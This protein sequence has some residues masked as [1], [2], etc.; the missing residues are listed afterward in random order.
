MSKVIFF[1]LPG[2]SGHI[3]PTV[4]LVKELI[5]RGEHVI[6]Y[7]G[8]DSRLKFTG[9]GAE[10]RTYEQWFDYQHNAEI[11]SS[12][13]PMAIEE[14]KMTMSSIDGLIAQAKEDEVDY[15]IYD[16]CCPWGKYVAASIGVPAINSITT[17]VSS[18]WI[19]LCDLKMGLFVLKTLLVGAPRVIPWARR[20]L[21]DML[22]RI[23]VPYQGILFHIFDFFASV[24]DKNIV[25]NTREYQPFDDKLVGDFEFV[26]ASIPERRDDIEDEFKDLEGKPLV[27]VSLGTLH[28]SDIAFYRNCIQAFR[29]TSYEVIMSVGRNINIPDL[30]DLPDNIKVYPFVPQLHILKY[31]K[32]FV[33]HGGMNSLNEGLYFGVPVIVCPQQF[34]QAFNG[35]R[36]QKLGIARTLQTNRPLPVDIFKA[37]SDVIEDEAMSKKVKE[38]SELMKKS[39]GYRRAADIIMDYV[40]SENIHNSGDAF[41]EDQPSNPKVPSSA[42]S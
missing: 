9:L 34:E 20:Q 10:F 2:A 8:E 36:L 19:L 18:P 35:R 1:N 24:G 7:A 26:G 21:I 4:G 32:A 30:G 11:G 16:S 5:S 33:T 12:L 13:L 23:N 6:Y 37:V 27:Y 25:F 15:I 22:V 39:G 28:N 17:I 14:L 40:G 38:Y 29:Y 41:L 42:S 3:N 31:A